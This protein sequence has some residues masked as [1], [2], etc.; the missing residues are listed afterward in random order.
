MKLLPVALLLLACSLQA[1][2]YRAGVASIDITPELPFWLTGFAA[3]TKPAEKVS[4]P[5][6]AKALALDDGAGG[7]IVIVTADLLGVTAEITT[8]VA[9]RLRQSHQLRRDQVL[10]NASH[11]HSG[12]SV[13]PRLHLA[14]VASPEV[15]R[16]V[17][18]YG[19]RLIDDF[20]SVARHALDNM[21][22]ATLE[23]GQTQAK[24]A[25]NRR[26]AQLAALHPGKSFPAPVDHTVPVWTVKAPDGSVR[27]VLFGYAC[28]NTVLTAGFTDVNGDY[29]GYAQQALERAFPQAAALFI[30]LCAGDQNPSPRGQAEHAVQHGESLAAAVRAKLASPMTPVRG[31]IRT[32]YEQIRLPFQA[33]TRDVYEAE[34][35]SANFFAARRAK[36]MLAAFDAKRPIVDTAYPVSVVRFGD[37]ATLVALGGEVVVDYALRLK[38]QFGPDR[39]VVAAYSNDVMG[40]IPS[41]RIQREGGYE[42]G[43]SMMY[44]IQP[45]WFTDEVERL[46]LDTARRLL[47]RVGTRS[48]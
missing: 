25:I 11:T 36:T 1:A 23:F 41:L 13:W 42:A 34:S 44:F 43:D 7:R 17:E 37:T 4:L 20:T 21:F 27:A 38:Q 33:H 28:H 12:P 40:Y 39:L 22:A 10:F 8:E 29:A 19:R 32:A 16:Q 3:R 46:V 18:A 14:P 24:F 45:G 26:V 31:P 35:S 6:H 47:A 5:I 48:K 2:G 9:A 30:A 15:D